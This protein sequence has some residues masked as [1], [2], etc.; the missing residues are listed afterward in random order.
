MTEEQTEY[1]GDMMREFRISVLDSDIEYVKKYLDTNKASL[2]LPESV[3]AILARVV[4][5]SNKF[6]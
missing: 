3:Y 1:A 2:T 4:I 5:C 6:I